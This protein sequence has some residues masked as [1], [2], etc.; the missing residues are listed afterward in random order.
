MNSKQGHVEELTFSCWGWSPSSAPRRW[1]PRGLPAMNPPHRGTVCPWCGICPRLWMNGPPTLSW[2]GRWSESCT[3]QGHCKCHVYFPL[4]V[5][6]FFSWKIWVTVCEENQLWQGC[7]AKATITSSSL[8]LS[9]LEYTSIVPSKHRS[10]VVS[11]SGTSRPKTTKTKRSVQ[12]ND[13]VQHV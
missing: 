2:V 6:L 13:F 12:Q 5:C 7:A 8:I 3:S 11:D 9:G 4:L 10:V 1:A